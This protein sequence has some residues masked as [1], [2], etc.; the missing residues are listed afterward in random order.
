MFG[1][2]VS[3]AAGERHIDDNKIRERCQIRKSNTD[4]DDIFRWVR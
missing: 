3:L 2:G 4:V 1:T